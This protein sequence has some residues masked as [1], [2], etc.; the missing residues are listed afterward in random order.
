MSADEI[1]NLLESKHIYKR[2]RLLKSDDDESNV[3]KQPLEETDTTQIEKEDEEPTIN[4]S[5]VIGEQ[6]KGTKTLL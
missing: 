4:S 5:Q 6:Q 2:T 3:T 1:V